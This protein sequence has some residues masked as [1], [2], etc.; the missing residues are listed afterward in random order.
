MDTEAILFGHF[1]SG[2]VESLVKIPDLTYQGQVNSVGGGLSGRVHGNLFSK[3]IG[4]GNLFA[5]W[6]EFSR[7]KKKKK[8]IAQLEF[9]LEENLFTLHEELSRKIYTHQPY[10]SFYICDPKLRHIHKASVRDRVLHQAVFRTLYPIFNKQFIF[11]SYSS[12]LSKGTHAAVKRLEAFAVKA[13]QNNRKNIF[14]LKCDVSKFFDSIDQNI[15]LKLLIKKVDDVGTIWLLEKIIRSF[16]KGLGRGLPLGNVTSQLFKNVYLN[17]L[18]QFVKHELKAKYYIRY[19]DDFLILSGNKNWLVK[20]IKPIR[21]FLHKELKLE[22]HPNKVFIRKLRQGIDFLGYVV[23]PYYTVLRTKTKKRIFKKIRQRKLEFETGKI[24]KGS[25]EQSLQSYLGILR[26]C[27]GYKIREK[28]NK[29]ADYPGFP[30][31]FTP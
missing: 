18:D 29:L 31:E 28:I 7:S 27:E 11:D 23:L 6:R 1:Q 2:E 21:I 17:E 9:N 8:D 25:F 20:Q 3:I 16:K 26:H 24:S 22:L 19:C 15:L 14:A 30:L 5:A 4:I 13:G 12:R 10:E